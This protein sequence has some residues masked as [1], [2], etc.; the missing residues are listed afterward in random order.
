LPFISPNKVSDCFIEDFMSSIPNDIKFKKYADY[1]I[2][3]Y[4]S[5]ETK[6]PPIIWAANIASLALTTKPPN[7]II[8]ISIPSSINHIHRRNYESGQSQFGFRPKHSIH[9]THRLIDEISSSFEMKQFCPGVFLDI[10]QAFDQ[11]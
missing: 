4:I 1:L 8:H 5:E 2:D 7:H 9:Q 10:A 3:T 6:F 11:V